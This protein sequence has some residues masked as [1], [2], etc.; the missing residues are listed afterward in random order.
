M[1]RLPPHSLMTTKYVEGMVRECLDDPQPLYVRGYPLGWVTV[2]RCYWV[3][4]V[5]VSQWLA[6]RLH[7]LH[8][9]EDE[10]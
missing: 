4:D 3:S 5:T 1:R 7:S 9:Q 8:R 6:R 2:C 10:P